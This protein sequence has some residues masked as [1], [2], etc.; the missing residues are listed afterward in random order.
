M[1]APLGMITPGV[2]RGKLGG[3]VKRG[4]GGR[5]GWNINGPLSEYEAIHPL[6]PLPL[7]PRLK[8]TIGV[9]WGEEGSLAMVQLVINSCIL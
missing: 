8:S 9:C 7:L 6:A 1:Y 3:K 4:F 5:K 2:E